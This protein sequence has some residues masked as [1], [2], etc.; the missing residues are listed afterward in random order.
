MKKKKEK[1]IKSEIKKTKAKLNN[2][3]KKKKK[4]KTTDGKIQTTDV[5]HH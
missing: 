5:M 3:I 1:N 2:R 4:K